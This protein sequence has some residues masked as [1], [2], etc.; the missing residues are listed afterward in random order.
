MSTRPNVIILILDACRRDALSPYVRRLPTERPT[1]PVLEK[2]AEQGVAVEDCQSTSSCTAISV[3]SIL[4]GIGPHRHGITTL[5]G[6]VLRDGVVSIGAHLRHVGYTTGFFPSSA[7]LN[8]M[9]RIG[10][11]FDH[12]DD[13]FLLPLYRDSSPGSGLDLP[14]F[15]RHFYQ[16][17]LT[18]TVPGSLQ[19]CEVTTG[20]VL[21]WMA[22]TPDPLLAVV[23]LIE[24]HYPYWPPPDWRISEDPLDR[25]NYHASLRYVD[26]A[27]VERVVD[28]LRRRGSDTLLLVTS[29]HGEYWGTHGFRPTG[30]HGDLYQDVLAVPLIAWGTGVEQLRPARTAPWSHLD[31]VPTVLGLLGLPVPRDLEGIDRSASD[32]EY[33][34]PSWE[35]AAFNDPAYAAAMGGF[36][37]GGVAVRMGRYKLIR[38][39]PGLGEPELYDLSVDPDE[40][41]NLIGIRPDLVQ[42]LSPRLPPLV[43]YSTVPAPGLHRRLAALGYL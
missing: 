42:V 11:A 24:P 22:R 23:H 20:A 4:T 30:D 5:V 41:R 16:P 32:E 9:T 34:R 25:R 14:L 7:V 1:T 37:R 3:S 38:R 2:L 17:P 40:R 31:V 6:A 28:V 27:C 43:A 19:F 35:D 10:D 26:A 29:D 18:R 15:R 33:P 36:R 13:D 21:A 12:V 8:R 39:A